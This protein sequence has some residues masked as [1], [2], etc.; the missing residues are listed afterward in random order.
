LSDNYTV[1]VQASA[2]GGGTSYAP[3]R[4][5]MRSAVF[6]SVTD[7]GCNSSDQMNVSLSWQ[8]NGSGAPA[9]WIQDATTPAFPGRLSMELPGATGTEQTGYVIDNKSSSFYWLI[10]QSAGAPAN[11]DNALQYTNLGGIYKCP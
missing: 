9:L 2:A 3:I 8:V 7:A 5:L 10:D 1:L 11:F 4:L 6:S